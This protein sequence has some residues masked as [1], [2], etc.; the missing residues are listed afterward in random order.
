MKI[1]LVLQSFSDLKLLIVS[2][3]CFYDVERLLGVAVR[4]RYHQTL[5]VSTEPFPQNR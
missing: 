5:V 2:W 3:S 4:E 1:A